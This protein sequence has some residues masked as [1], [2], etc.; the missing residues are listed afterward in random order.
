MT[1]RRTFTVTLAGEQYLVEVEV[2]WQALANHLGARA[3]FNKTGRS[4]LEGFSG[5]TLAVARRANPK[6]RKDNP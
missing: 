6:E 3:V 5:K 1:E 2:D 4:A